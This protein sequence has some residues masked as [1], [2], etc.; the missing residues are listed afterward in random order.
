MKRMSQIVYQ[1]DFTLSKPGFL[2]LLNSFRNFIMMSTKEKL[3]DRLISIIQELPLSKLI[4]LSMFIK[5]F[6]SYKK[7]KESTLKMA[8]AWKDL[9]QDLFLDLTDRL[10]DRRANDRPII[11]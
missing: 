6:K 7:S 2:R 8:G 10:H 1:I 4:E 5:K 11:L 9:D 3:T